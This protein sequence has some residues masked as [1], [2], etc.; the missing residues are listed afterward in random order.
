MQAT[1]KSDR[2]SG[3][4][5]LPKERGLIPKEESE[6]HKNVFCFSLKD[7]VNP[8]SYLCISHLDPLCDNQ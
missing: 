8:E 1:V 2:L 5:I 7:L 3:P 4:P 6:A